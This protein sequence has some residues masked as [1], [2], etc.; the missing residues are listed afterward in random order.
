MQPGWERGRLGSCA[1][2]LAVPPPPP[3]AVPAA[4]LQAR[5]KRVAPGCPHPTGRQDAAGVPGGEAQLDAGCEHLLPAVLVRARL[6]GD[7]P[8]PQGQCLLL[9]RLSGAEGRGSG[10]GSAS[11]WLLLAGGVFPRQPRGPCL[12]PLGEAVGRSS[13]KGKRDLVVGRRVPLPSSSL[14]RQPP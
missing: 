6:G 8:P 13:R 9:L 10:R 11:R 5:L 12:R 7:T 14:P 1:L 4:S 2:C 3:S